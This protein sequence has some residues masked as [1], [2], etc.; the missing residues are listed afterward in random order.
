MLRTTGVARYEHEPMGAAQFVELVGRYLADHRSIFDNEVRR[1]KL[2]ECI[3]L[4]VEAG[5][6]EARLLFQRLPELIQ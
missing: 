6:P 5:W 2:M 3:A 4:F 1:A